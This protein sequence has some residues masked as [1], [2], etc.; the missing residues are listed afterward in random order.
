MP[1]LTGF[2][3]VR[4]PRAVNILP[5]RRRDGP[6]RARHDARHREIMTGLAPHVPDCPLDGPVF[7]S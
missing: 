2:V 7:G 4:A 3:T 1:S 6:G 5:P